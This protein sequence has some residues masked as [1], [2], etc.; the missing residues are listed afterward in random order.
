MEEQVLGI[1]RTTESRPRHTFARPPETRRTHRRLRCG[2]AFTQDAPERIR[3]LQITVAQQG[4]PA[5]FQH[6]DG[7]VGEPV[8]GQ[9]A[10]VFDAGCI[11]VP[12]KILVDATKDGG[13]WWFPQ[14]GLFE[15]TEPH[16]GERLA[17][18]MRSRGNIVMELGRDALITSELLGEYA[19]VFAT[20]PRLR[21]ATKN[22]RA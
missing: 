22:R 19:A 18:Y 14:D 7:W 3:F 15:E 4:V 6:G 20:C 11:P 16:Q 10:R 2:F 21:A 1:L 9:S 5:H 8:P 13:I 17:D 12:R